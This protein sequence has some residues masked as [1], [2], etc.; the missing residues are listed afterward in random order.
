MKMGFVLFAAVAV[1]ASSACAQESGVSPGEMPVEL[2]TLTRDVLGA[3]GSITP[4]DYLQKIS[5][6]A[7]DSMGGRDTPSPGLEMTAA[8]IAGEFERLGLTPGG[9][10]GG[11]LQRY[12]LPVVG[13][14][15]AAP[16]EASTAP[17]VVAILEGSDPALRDE[18]IVFSAH[19]DHIGTGP[20]NANGDSINNGADDDASGTTAI[21]ELAEAFSAMAVKPKRSMIFLTVSGE[22]K[23]LWGSDYFANNPPVSVDRMVANLN[24]DMIG[25]NWSDTIVAIGKEHSDLGVTLN[26]VNAEHPELGMTAID[27]IWPDQR[28]YFRSD[29][30]SFAK[31]G[32][33]ILFFFNGTHEDYHGEDDEVDRIDTD[34]AARI[35]K[36]LFFLGYELGER[37]ARPQWYPESRSQIVTEG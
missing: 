20:P 11:F 32:V 37:S 1:G 16:A 22:E 18:Y 24:V 7:H 4:S 28:F 25:R 12:V 35:T 34:K 26:Q 6:I 13:P 8:W 17:N 29:H 21:L 36:L 23:G 9:D 31:K 30:F 14:E 19:M 27:D 33:P 3:A 5:V 2:A 10:D 15:G